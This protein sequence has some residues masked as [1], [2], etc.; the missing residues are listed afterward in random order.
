MNSYILH[1][2]VQ[3]AKTDPQLGIYYWPNYKNMLTFLIYSKEGSVS[4]LG[5]DFYLFY[6]P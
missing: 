3:I 1:H 5:L 4:C 2:L 6:W